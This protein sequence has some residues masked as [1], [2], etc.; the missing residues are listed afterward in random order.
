[1]RTSLNKIKLIDDYLS[2]NMPVADSL[3]FEAN[4]LLNAEL[5]DDVALQKQIHKVIR[6]YGRQSIKAEIA[7]ARYKLNTEA[8]YGSF[9]QRIADLFKKH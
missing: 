8:K 9:M 3:L 7:A 2:D 6:V 4:I 5:A 1:M